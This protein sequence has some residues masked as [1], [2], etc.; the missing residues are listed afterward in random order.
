MNKMKLEIDSL[1]VESFQTS[2][3]APEAQ[4]SRADA[5]ARG[6]VRAHGWTRLGDQT[7]GGESCDYA[8]ITLYDATCVRVCA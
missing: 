6:T 3:P 5:A 8:C 2:R 4:A 7:C 1:M